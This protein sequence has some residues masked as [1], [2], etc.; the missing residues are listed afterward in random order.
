MPKKKKEKP[1][2][3]E[4][5]S[6]NLAVGKTEAAPDTTDHVTGGM[7]TPPTNEKVIADETYTDA[8]PEVAPMAQDIILG[9]HM[10]LRNARIQYL[11]LL[12]EKIKM[13][14][15]KAVVACVQIT[16][17]LLRLFSSC[18]FVITIHGETWERLTQSQRVALIDHELCHCIKDEDGFYGTRG[19]DI[20]EFKEIV[21]RH[22]FWRND[23]R[24][25]AVIIQKEFEFTKGKA[26]ARPEK[27]E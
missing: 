19:H 20:E 4:E 6:E 21:E 8:N 26:E 23:V 13:S 9:H 3:S 27:N 24:E 11:F 10:H 15:G 12:G 1:V 14:K 16:S 17:G 25:M 22:G 18:D 7:D 5:G 2:G